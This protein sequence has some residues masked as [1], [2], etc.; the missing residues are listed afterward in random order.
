MLRIERPELLRKL[1]LTRLLH[2]SSR[3]IVRWRRVNRQFLNS[4]GVSSPTQGL[5]RSS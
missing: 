2:V 1:E 5:E 3:A 4:Q